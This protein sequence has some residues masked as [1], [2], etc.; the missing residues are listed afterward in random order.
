M[1]QDELFTI[2]ARGDDSAVDF[3]SMVREIAHIWDDLIDKDKPVSE[4]QINDAFLMALVGLPNNRFYSSNFSK[5]NPILLSAAN[6]WRV[7]NALER[8]GDIEDKRIAFVIRS[9][10]ADLI[11]QTAFIIGGSE[12]VEEI[13]PH[14][15]RFVHAEGWDN[16]LISL[17][18]AARQA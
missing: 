8:Q 17:E 7:A 1:T 14:I 11:I 10:Y 18:Q 13:G 5:L 3:L 2:V 16:Y 15:R 9:A 12:W 6:N 4:H